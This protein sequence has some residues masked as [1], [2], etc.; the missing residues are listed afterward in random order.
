MAQLSFLCDRLSFYSVVI[1]HR[2][3]L[4]ELPFG[5]S[6]KQKKWKR[7]FEERR[8][9]LCSIYMQ[10]KDPRTISTLQAASIFGTFEGNACIKILIASLWFT[11]HLYCDMA[12]SG[13]KYFGWVWLLNIILNFT[14]FPHNPYNGVVCNDTITATGV[15][16]SSEL[17]KL[18]KGM[19]QSIC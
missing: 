19:L 7:G 9:F 18:S 14:G 2:V 6:T 11:L 1:H 17:W 3:R 12:I 8:L 5:F 4:R 10:K 16:G 15:F 13:D